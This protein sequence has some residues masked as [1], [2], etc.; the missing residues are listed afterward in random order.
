M[1]FDLKPN[2]EKRNF[3]SAFYK[4]TILTESY[5]LFLIMIENK[6]KTVPNLDTGFGTE[7]VFFSHCVIEVE[8]KIHLKIL[9]L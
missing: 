3:I 8:L 2:Q 5:V 7:H 6:E 4:L 9:N 1:A